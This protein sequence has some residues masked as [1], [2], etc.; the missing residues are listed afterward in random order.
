[1][2]RAQKN[3]RLGKGAGKSVQRQPT[4]LPYGSKGRGV[5]KRTGLERDGSVATLNPQDMADT[6]ARV[7]K[8]RS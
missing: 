1:M 5:V 3:V 2:S 8:T 7:I 4:A 6:Q